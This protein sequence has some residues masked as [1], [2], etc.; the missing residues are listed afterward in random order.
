MI[1]SPARAPQS[2][3]VLGLAVALLVGPRT[4][5]AQPV[6]AQV[7]RVQAA[8]VNLGLTPDMSVPVGIP[9]RER[10]GSDVF[11]NSARVQFLSSKLVAN[12][13]PTDL[14]LSVMPLYQYT[15]PLH[16][17]LPGRGAA[18]LVVP[19]L[20]PGSVARDIPQGTLGVRLTFYGLD[21]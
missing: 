9:V 6:P 21:E 11:F 5:R 3:L 13:G 17:A 18:T 15:A 4:A 16:I 10:A 7:E 20:L 1:R 2:L 12:T 14:D 8:N 19:V